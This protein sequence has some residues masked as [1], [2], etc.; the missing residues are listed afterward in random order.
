MFGIAILNVPLS[1]TTAIL[2]F[3]R[4]V[5][6]DA[7]RKQLSANTDNNRRAL[8]LLNERVRQTARQT[9]LPVLF[10]TDL[11]SHSGSFGGQLSSAIQAVFDRGFERILVVGND[12]PALTV[13]DLTNAAT[14]LQAGRVV[15]GPD[16]RGGAY[17]LGL[18]RTQFDADV[19]R[20]LPWQTNQLHQAICAQFAAHTVLPLRALS[21]INQTVDIRTYRADSEATHSFICQL[22]RLIDGWVN[23]FNQVL[24]HRAVQPD[25]YRTGPL[26]APPFSAYLLHCR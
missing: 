14:E 1:V 15:L 17:L 22:L 7:T 3:A 20:E 19:L 8:H 18:S 6:H 10:S 24:I 9:G 12:C 23:F 25:V 11:I 16:N 21:D 26:R 2:V 13:G 5:A 4:P